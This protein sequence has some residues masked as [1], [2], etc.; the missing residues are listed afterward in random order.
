MAAGLI[1]GADYIGIAIDF[2]FV[3]F[4]QKVITVSTCNRFRNKGDFSTASGSVDNI[5]WEPHNLWYAP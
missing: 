1:A 4:D 5:S 2:P 3:V